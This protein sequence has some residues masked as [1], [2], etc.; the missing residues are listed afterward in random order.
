[1]LALRSASAGGEKVIH[2]KVTSAH[3]DSDSEVTGP[4]LSAN[5]D[6]ANVGVKKGLMINT[7]LFHVRNH[8]IIAE[9]AERRIIYLDMT[10][11]K[12]RMPT[13]DVNRDLRRITLKQTYGIHDCTI[14]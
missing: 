5:I 6:S 3:M 8:T 12:Q 9:I 13:S 14:P 10:F 2:L 4:I 7:C 11:E 1:M